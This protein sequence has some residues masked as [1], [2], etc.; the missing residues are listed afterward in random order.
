MH[1]ADGGARVDRGDWRRVPSLRDD[2][3][4]GASSESLGSVPI[5]PPRWLGL[6]GLLLLGAA[7]HRA[8]KHTRFGMPIASPLFLARCCAPRLFSPNCD[9][10][11]HRFTYMTS[12][13]TRATRFRIDA[14]ERLSSGFLRVQGNL[15]KTGVFEYSFGSDVV[16]ELRSDSE[17]FRSDSLDSLLGAPVTVDHPASMVV[18][19]KNVNHLTVGNVIRAERNDPY[20]SGTMQIHDAKTIAMVEAGALVEVSLGYTCDPV[21]HNDSNIAD[22]EQKNIVYN[23]AALGPSGWGRLGGDVSLRLDSQ[24]NIDFAAFTEAVELDPR[25]NEVVENLTE[26]LK[27]L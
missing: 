5:F 23:H 16:R 2:V 10:T 14:H 1:I 20:I 11:L 13:K 17:V 19:T 26:I 4:F 21:E 6:L 8:K 15:T 7:Q 27:N 24:G 12:P 3:L 22:F 25:W 9:D 18:D